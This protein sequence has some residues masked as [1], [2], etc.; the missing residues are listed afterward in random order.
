MKINPLLLATSLLITALCIASTAQAGVRF[1]QGNVTASAT[2]SLS[3]TSRANPNANSA[4]DTIYAFT[5]ALN[6]SRE[7]ARLNLN[8]NLSAPFRRYDSQGQLDS[9]SLNFT[10]NGNIPYGAGPR[11]SGSWSLSYFDGVQSNF[12]LNRNLNSENFQAGIS[13]NYRLRNRLGLKTRLSYSDRSSSG[14]GDGFENSNETFLYSIGLHAREIVGTIGAYVEYRVQDRQ[15][16]RGFMPI[17]IDDTDKGLNFGVTGQLLPERLFP[18]LE[19]DLSFGFT[20]TNNLD[21]RGSD[22][23]R[24]NLNGSLRYPANARTNVALHFGRNLRITDDDRT[25]EQSSISLNVQYTP[26][27]KLALSG[28]IG[29]SSNDF[30]DGDVSRDDDVFTFGANATY[31]IR[32]NWKAS[33]AYSNRESSSTRSIAD[34]GS[35]LITLSTTIS[36]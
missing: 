28:N 15:T 26:R 1:A 8:A 24:L 2:V 19:A 17:G 23:N 3:E 29:F 5:P 36:Y 21:D 25:V 10:L 16:T 9:D 6:Y 31:S 35:S 12:L 20:S 18:K 13:S 22:S 11:F 27:Q 7:S 32:Q 33:L 34:F 14:I 4:S 30:L